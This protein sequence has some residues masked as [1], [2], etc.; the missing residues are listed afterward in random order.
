MFP[1]VRRVLA[2]KEPRSLG[3]Q[4]AGGDGVAPR[5]QN[6]VRPTKDHE[7]KALRAKRF[8]VHLL[9]L[10]V[11]LLSISA[12]FEFFLGCALNRSPKRFKQE[13]N[14]SYLIDPHD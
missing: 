5:S 12:A 6:T 3:S 11:F 13:N 2:E 14:S 4:W 9:Q 8:S 1:T 10:L 7:E